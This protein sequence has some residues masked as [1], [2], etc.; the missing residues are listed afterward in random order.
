MRAQLTVLLLLLAMVSQPAMAQKKKEVPYPFS[1][2][3]I[4][5]TPDYGNPDCWAALPFKEDKA[6]LTPSKRIKQ[7]QDSAQIDVFFVHPTTY[8]KGDPWNADVYDQELNDYT[9]EMPIRH[10]A[11]VFNGSCRVFAPRYRQANIRAY[12]HLNEGG[13]EALAFAYADVKAAFEYYLEHYNNGRPIIIASHS[14]GTTHTIRLMKEFFD[15]TPLANQLVAAYLVGMPFKS[16]TYTALAPCNNASETGCYVAWGTYAEGFFPGFYDTICK[17][18]VSINPIN[19]TT[20]TTFSK[21][22]AAKGL[23]GYRFKKIHR[24]AVQARVHDGLL[25]I[26][27]PRVPFA[28]LLKMEIYHI[29]DYNLFWMDIRENVALRAKMYFENHSASGQ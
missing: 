9:D 24:R 10:Q 17:G 2:S 11:S 14:Q 23:A 28:F 16:A 8:H 26:T 18:S 15:G 22:D 29:A 27:R 12:Y 21:I 1:E 7:H 20:D 6:D 25:W 19:W 3:P 4:P 13:K 5:P